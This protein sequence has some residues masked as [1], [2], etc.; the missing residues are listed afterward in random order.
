MARDKVYGSVGPAKKKAASK[1]VAKT[2]NYSVPGGEKAMSR[3]GYLTVGGQA[4]A[5]AMKAGKKK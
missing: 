1:R 2:K 3:A 5:K 4:M